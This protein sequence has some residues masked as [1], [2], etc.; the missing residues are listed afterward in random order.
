MNEEI[1]KNLTYQKHAN[2]YYYTLDEAM[3]VWGT[4]IEDEHVLHLI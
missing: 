4:Q 3:V 2:Q 1:R